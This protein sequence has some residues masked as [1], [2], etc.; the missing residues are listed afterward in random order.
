MKHI[1]LIATVLRCAPVCVGTFAVD[2][3][4]P[5]EVAEVL[6]SHAHA[7]HLAQHVAE[8]RAPELVQYETHYIDTELLEAGGREPIKSRDGFARKGKEK[9]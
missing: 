5:Q 1:N 6:A 4:Q 9:A 2:D 3:K 8:G 7:R